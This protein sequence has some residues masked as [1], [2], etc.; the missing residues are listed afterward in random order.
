M[1]QSIPPGARGHVDARASLS[2]SWQR[3]QPWNAGEGAPSRLAKPMT[4][5]PQRD[6]RERTDDDALGVKNFGAGVGLVFGE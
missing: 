4:A 3:A 6:E 2:R 5:N 1:P